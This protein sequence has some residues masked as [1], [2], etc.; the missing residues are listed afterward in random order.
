MLNECCW[1]RQKAYFLLQPSS[2]ARY[3]NDRVVLK[4]RKLNVQNALSVDV[5]REACCSFFTKGLRI[6]MRQMQP[7]YTKKII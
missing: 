6:I 5:V 7:Q 4:I 3:N 1:E 2:F